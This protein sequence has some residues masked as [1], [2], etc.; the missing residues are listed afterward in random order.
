[1][2]FEPNEEEARRDQAL[3]HA[4]MSTASSEVW[5][6]HDNDTKI[7]LA[8]ADKFEQWLKEGTTEQAVPQSD[9]VLPDRSGAL[10]QYLRGGLDAGS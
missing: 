2:M 5:R 9:S 7:I 3:H 6:T 10:G 1:M 8:R 4:I